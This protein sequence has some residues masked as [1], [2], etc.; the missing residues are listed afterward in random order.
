MNERV[1]FVRYIFETAPEISS[2]YNRR[3]M[4]DGRTSESDR[5]R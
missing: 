1:V 3:A 4:G 2:E 5:R